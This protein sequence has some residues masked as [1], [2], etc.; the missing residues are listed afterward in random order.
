MIIERAEEGARDK[1]IRGLVFISGKEKGFIVGA[2]VREFEQ[3]TDETQVVDNVIAHQRLPRSPGAAA[4]PGGLLHPR[5][6]PRRRPG[7]GAGL[8]LAH[9]HA[10]RRHPHRLPRGEA[11]AVPRLQRHGALD[12]PGRRAVRHAADADGLVHPRHRRARHGADRRAGAEPPQPAL[13]GA[14]GGRAQAQVEAGGRLAGA[15]ADVAGTRPAGQEVAHRDGQ[16]G[17]RG[18]LSRAVPPDRS[19]RDARRQSRRHE[20]GGDARLRA[21]DGRRYLAATC[22]ACSSCPR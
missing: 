17:A 8:P 20:A 1:S 7:A 12:P 3:L 15:H 19:V 11:R 21:A 18:A 4:D 2:D 13:D 10:R 14:Q 9:R 22:A 5:L 6:L 16:E